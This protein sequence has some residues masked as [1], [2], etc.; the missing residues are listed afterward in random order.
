MTDLFVVWTPASLF[1]AVIGGSFV[2]FAFVSRFDN[3]RFT[4][5][6]AVV[7]VFVLWAFT[8]LV[9]WAGQMV[10]TLVADGED[11]AWRV[12]SRSLLFL[13]YAAFMGIGTGLGVSRRRGGREDGQ[14]LPPMVT[15]DDLSVQ[16]HD[17]QRLAAVSSAHAEAAYTAAS[18][19][20]DRVITQ[21]ERAVDDRARSNRIEDTGKDTNERAQD[22][23]GRLNGNG[24]GRP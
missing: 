14:A 8:G 2:G 9:F 11:N 16:L 6:Q 18:D 12:V 20:D 5:R 4:A 23:Q 17:I 10:E 21:A 19:A 7:V 22:I 3:P 13:V 24:E 15:L 1:A